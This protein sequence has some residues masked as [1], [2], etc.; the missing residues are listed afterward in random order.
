MMSAFV[1]SSECFTFASY[2]FLLVVF[3]P[4]RNK[5]AFEYLKTISWHALK[6]ST[7]LQTFNWVLNIAFN[8]KCIIIETIDSAADFD[9]LSELFS[10]V[11]MEIRL[12]VESDQACARSH[13]HAKYHGVWRRLVEKWLENT[14]VSLMPNAMWWNHLYDQCLMPAKTMLWS[15]MEQQS[16]GP[17][18]ISNNKPEQSSKLV[19]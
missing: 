17:L 12:A 1:G 6:T 10:I 5:R 14:K 8:L 11:S 16:N 2:L 13:I 4:S 19:A 7:R 18:E 15:N 9:N 3:S